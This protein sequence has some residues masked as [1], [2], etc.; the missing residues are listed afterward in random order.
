MRYAAQ[1]FGTWEWLDLEVPFDTDGPE[2]ALSTY[3]I[4]ECTI[5]PEIGLLKAEDGR[6]LLEEWGTF[7]HVED[8][9][10]IRRWT[11]IVVESALEGAEWKVTVWEFP[12]YLDGLPVESLIRGVK[13]DPADLVRQIWLEAQSK[14]HS[15]HGASVEGS[16]PVRIGTDSDDK[17]AAARA[18]M[19]A[20]RATLD[21]LNKSKASATKDLQDLTAT[22]ADEVSQARAQLTAA[23]SALSTLIKDNASS[24]EVDTARA[25]VTA[26]QATLTQAQ[27]AS[28]AETNAGKAAK[29]AAKTNKDAAQKAYDAAQKAYD[30]AK[31]KAQEDG[32]AYEIRSEDLKDSLDAVNDLCDEAGLEWYTSTTYST[33]EPIL[34][35]HVRSPKV[36][37]RRD[38]LVFEQGVNIISELRL[39]RGKDYANAAIGVG[40]G[41]G[42]KAVRSAVASTSPRMRRVTVVEDKSI[43]TVSAMAPIM[44]KDLNKRTGDPFV[45]TITVVDT[46]FA[47][48]FSWNVGDTITVSGN[49]P[50]YG[51]YS[52]LHRITAWQMKGEYQA[53]LTLELA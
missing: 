15:W 38:D 35:V 53:E 41:E 36:G 14:P 1:R 34:T 33:S 12:G 43:K 9:N 22:L 6:L 51:Y 5:A 18:T 24:A 20:R 30:S 52:K 48:M 50:H 2:Y 11:G 8:D 17:V 49:V 4:M 40:A 29:A 39:T 3:G 47:P 26:R 37:T 27:T 21:A 13:A 44:Q 16:T 45:A 7:I 46:P 19:D 42:D 32:G 10:N 31:D 25:V 28:T 23:Q